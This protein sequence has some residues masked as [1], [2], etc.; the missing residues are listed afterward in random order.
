MPIVPMRRRR[1][2]AGV[3]VVL[4]VVLLAPIAIAISNEL[5]PQAKE[6]T[7]ESRFRALEAE[8]VELRC[9]PDGGS[10]SRG[11]GDW[12]IWRPKVPRH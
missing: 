12:P 2:W 8:R 10:V 3:A 9:T 6:R 4:T 1:Q 7:V 5:E 11:P